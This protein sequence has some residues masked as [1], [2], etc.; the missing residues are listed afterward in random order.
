MAS[1]SETVLLALLAALQAEMPSGV[2][3]QRNEVLPQR[4]P[5]AGVVILGDGSPGEPDVLLSPVS[6]YYEH[7]ADISIVVDRLPSE[8]D[9]AFDLLK[10]SVGAALAVDRTLGGLCDYVVA[11]APAPLIIA[12]EGGDSLK[13]ATI[14]VVLSYGSADP[15]L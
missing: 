10:A 2:V 12:V 15:L 7:R 3:V 14:P 13:G 4:I 5:A 6:Y 8:R 1:K 9:A 11:E